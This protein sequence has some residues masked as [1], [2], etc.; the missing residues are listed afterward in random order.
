LE[1]LKARV[2]DAAG[3]L[4]LLIDAALT[5]ARPAGEPAGRGKRNSSE[6]FGGLAV[7]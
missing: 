6:R 7:L 3:R 5:Q 2:P 1:R 4:K